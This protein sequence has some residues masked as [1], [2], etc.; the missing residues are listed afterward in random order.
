MSTPPPRPPA[1]PPVQKL[2]PDMS[3]NWIGATES[4]VW[5]RENGGRSIGPSFPGP[6]NELPGSC[7][8][9]SAYWVTSSVQSFMFSLKHFTNVSW[10]C[11]DAA[12]PVFC[13]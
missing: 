9:M 12:T 2:D 13:A 10:N 8:S 4:H 6:G 11:L 1:P 5:V 7:C 3:T